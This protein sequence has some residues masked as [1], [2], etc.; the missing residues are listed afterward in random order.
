MYAV[1]LLRVNTWGQDVTFTSPV[2]VAFVPDPCAGNVNEMMPEK[3]SVVE[4][5]T[6]GVPLGW[7][8]GCWTAPCNGR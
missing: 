8:K 7:A 6:V 1:R 4:A 2:T 5:G 3:G